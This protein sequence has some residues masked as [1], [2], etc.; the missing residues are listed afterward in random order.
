MFL[1]RGK[2]VKI[3]YVVRDNLS[4]S[5]GYIVWGV[6]E[7]WEKIIQREVCMLHILPVV[8]G[9]GLYCHYAIVLQV[10]SGW[11]LRAESTEIG[12]SSLRRNPKSTNYRYSGVQN[13]QPIPL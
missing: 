1:I 10:R 2:C 7:E 11:I 9:L 4:L 5:G 8:C 12:C 3:A 6:I 13:R